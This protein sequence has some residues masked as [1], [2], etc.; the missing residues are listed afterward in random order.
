MKK[1]LSVCVLAL[2]F[3]INANA[4]DAKAKAILDNVTKKVN[5]L[6]T[7]KANFAL[8]LTGG[9]VND[10][11]KGTIAIKGTKYH[12]QLTGQE[13]ICDNKTVWTYNADAKEVT[14][15]SFNPKDQSISPAKLLT[16]FYDKEYRYKYIGERTEG[17]KKCDV[18]EL[19]PID[20]NK[21][22]TKIELL[23]DKSNSMI[24]GGNIW[25]KNGNKTT[26]MISNVVTDKPIADDFFTWNAKAHPG[27]EVNDLR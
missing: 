22:T 14:V 27:V 13:I 10:S 1:L 4:Q 2:S 21:Q 20:A 7:I 3:A 9:K 12:V 5:T 8:K 19:T 17:G 16:N 18:I 24:A 26:Y 6:K 11:K 15:S 25:A 23:I